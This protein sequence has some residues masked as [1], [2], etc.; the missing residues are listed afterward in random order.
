MIAWCRQDLC[1]DCRG[2]GKQAFRLVQQEHAGRTQS[3]DRAM[4]GGIFAALSV[5][6]AVDFIGPM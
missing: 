6:E 2:N 1:D 5:R 4:G 3:S